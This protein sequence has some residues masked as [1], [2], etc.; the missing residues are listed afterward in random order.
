MPSLHDLD[1]QMSHMMISDDDMDDNSSECSYYSL[2]DLEDDPWLKQIP[3]HEV[4]KQAE[5]VPKVVSPGAK[6]PHPFYN[7]ERLQLTT[8]GPWLETLCALMADTTMTPT[9]RLV[10]PGSLSTRRSLEDMTLST[11]RERRKEAFEKPYTTKQ[12][13]GKGYQATLHP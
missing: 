3:A 8:A 5:Q 7:K 6:Y 11:T 4:R 1:G 10:L 9:G 13:I 12:D 2:P